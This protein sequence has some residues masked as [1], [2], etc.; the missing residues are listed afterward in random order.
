MFRTLTLVS[1]AGLL[2]FASQA[3]AQDIRVSLAGKDAAEIRADIEKAAYQVCADFLGADSY[4]MLS[5][6]AACETSQVADAYAQIKDSDLLAELEAA[7]SSDAAVI[8]V[9]ANK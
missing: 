6:M 9:A 3:S 2:A 7:P 8:S 5:E 1:A 4:H